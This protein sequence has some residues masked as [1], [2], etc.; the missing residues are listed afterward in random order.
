MISSKNLSDSIYK[1]SKDKSL[2]KDDVLNAIL[3]YIKTYKLES[4]LKQTVKHL[5]NKEK[6]DLIWDTLNIESGLA[7]D[8]SIVNDIKNKLNAKEAGRTENK[9]KKD[10]IGGFRATYR[11]VIYDASI[12]NQLQLLRNTLTK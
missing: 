9:I 2:K 3:D 11:G 10:L 12:K 8:D 1:L 7:I 5:E 6:K 4:L